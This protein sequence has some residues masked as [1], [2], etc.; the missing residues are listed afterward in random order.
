MDEEQFEKI[1]LFFFMIFMDEDKKKKE[2]KPT[3]WFRDIF[4]ERNQKEHKTTLYKKSDLQIMKCFSGSTIN[5]IN[6][7]MHALSYNMERVGAKG[8]RY[9]QVYVTSLVL[10]RCR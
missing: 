8:I 5:Y 6:I 2:K 3:T 7:V 4:K 10:R 9:F 1:I